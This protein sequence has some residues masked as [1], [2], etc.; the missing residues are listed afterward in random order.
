MKLHKIAFV[1]VVI[2]GLNWGLVALGQFMGG[3]NWNVVNLIL[4]SYSTVENLVYLLVGFS[5][6]SL[7]FSHKGDCREC[8][9]SGM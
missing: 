2:G 4:G 3:A 6:L 7:V 1:L 8:N 5:A 9:P